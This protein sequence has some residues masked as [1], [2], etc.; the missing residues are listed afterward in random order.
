MVVPLVD[1]SQ[2]ERQRQ[3]CEYTHSKYQVPRAWKIVSVTQTQKKGSRA[4][5]STCAHMIS[6]MRVLVVVGLHSL[7]VLPCHP[8]RAPTPVQN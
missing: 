2:C 5:D 4:C 8:N 1:Y 6:M 7:G 3:Q